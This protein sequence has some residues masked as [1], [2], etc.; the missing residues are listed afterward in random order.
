MRRLWWPAFNAE[1]SC[2]GAVADSEVDAMT[3]DL[4]LAFRLTNMQLDVNGNAA[5]AA[6]LASNV[7][8]VSRQVLGADHPATAKAKSNLASTYHA[9]G[10]HKDAMRLREEVVAFSERVLPADHPHTATAKNN[11]AATYHALGR[12]KDA[13]RL[14]EE[15]VAFRELSL[16]HI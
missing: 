6:A 5:V 12:Y 14:Q 16:I 1:C 13:M 2:A 7:V 4:G 10:R 11:L 9:L 8:A 15:V 3:A